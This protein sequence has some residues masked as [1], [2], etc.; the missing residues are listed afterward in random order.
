[1]QKPLIDS[2]TYDTPFGSIFAAYH[3]DLP[4][5]FK[6]QFLMPADA[7][8]YILLNGQMDKVWHRPGWL[9]P[10]FWVLS[11]F[12][13]L[14]PETGN[15]IPASMTIRGGYNRRQEPYH[16]WHRTFFFPKPRHFNAVMAFNSTADR[17]VELLG[18]HRLLE[19][20]WDIQF[21]PPITIK[22]VT[23][24]C[25]IR[26]GNRRVSLPSFAYPT[27]RA[28]ETI[29]DKKQKKIN[30]KLIVTHDWFGDVFGYNGT[31]KIRRMYHPKS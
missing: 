16:L 13:M 29:A 10:F 25:N 1:M 24:T 14:F 8:F 3:N 2:H 15:D 19:M 4:T 30:V 11:W 17:V 23:S 6:D 28:V 5:L 21:K 27:V 9:K 31:F 12:D 18:P 22:I 26:V 7:P 20:Q